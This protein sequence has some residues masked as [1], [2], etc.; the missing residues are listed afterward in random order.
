MK[1]LWKFLGSMRFAI[2]LLVILAA[3]CAGGSFITQGLS[4]EAEAE[5]VT[6]ENIIEEVI[7]AVI[8]VHMNFFISLLWRL[9][10]I[11][12]V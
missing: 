1:K 10:F 4:Y 8:G 11:L 5:N 12:W 2:I 3:A 6:A 7:N 9:M